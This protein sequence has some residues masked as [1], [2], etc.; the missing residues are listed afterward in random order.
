MSLLPIYDKLLEQVNNL[1]PND[2]IDID[3]VCHTINNIHKHLPKQD[4]EHHH[5]MIGSLIIHH[6]MITDKI[7]IMIFPYHSQIM[8]GGRGI[9]PSMED[10][11]PLLQ[12][13]IAQ[14]VMNYSISS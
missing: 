10:L 1:G 2:Q 13:I 9:L 4:V 6:K 3:R 12:K 7:D 14:Y 5:S 8:I 11:P